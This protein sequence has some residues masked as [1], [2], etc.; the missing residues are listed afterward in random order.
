MKLY[1]FH[2]FWFCC[3]LFV[4][5]YPQIGTYFRVLIS[6]VHEFSVNRQPGEI[7]VRQP[8]L[9]NHPIIFILSAIFINAF[10]IY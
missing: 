8:F 6:K 3:A 2:S 4:M 1:C 5:K 9:F 10:C 7:S